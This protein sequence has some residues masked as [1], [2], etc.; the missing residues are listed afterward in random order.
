MSEVHVLVSKRGIR[1]IVHLLSHVYMTTCTFKDGQQVSELW[2]NKHHNYQ[3]TVIIILASIE[4]THTVIILNLGY[5][6]SLPGV[7]VIVTRG[8]CNRYLGYMYSLP[9]VHVFVT[10]GTCI[11]YLGY[12]YLLPGM[13]LFLLCSIDD[14]QLIH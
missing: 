4:T 10:R 8:T 5:M 13:H 14:L 6:Y 9:G 11:C 7:H 1:T 2:Y 3:Y 12:M